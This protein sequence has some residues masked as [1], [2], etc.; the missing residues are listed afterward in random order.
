MENPIKRHE[1]AALYFSGGKDSLA[2]LYLLRAYWDDLTVVWCNTGDAFPET[3]AQMEEI[4]YTVPNFLEVKSDQPEQRAR[5]GP[6]SDVVCAWET[7]IGR[8]MKASPRKMQTAFGCCAENIWVPL[9]KTMMNLGFTLI[10]HGQRSDELRKAPIQSG[11]IE[12]GIEYYLP[13]ETWSKNDVL[14]FLKTHGI[15]LPEHY[16]YVDSSLDCQHCTGYLDESVGKFTYMEVHHP[17]L[18][19]RVQGILGDI[20]D[21]IKPELRRMEYLREENGA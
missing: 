3:L 2:C 17:E 10:I 18:Y 6:P 20:I 12:H 9:H 5:C 13:L 1:R 19:R 21:G 14:L 8:S 16:S 15:K 11:H 7:P 4:R